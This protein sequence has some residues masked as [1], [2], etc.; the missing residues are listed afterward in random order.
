[1]FIHFFNRV[2]RVLYEGLATGYSRVARWSTF[3][4]DTHRRIE[5]LRRNYITVVKKQKGE[6]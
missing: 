4:P 6:R 1:M 5:D 2:R 3:K